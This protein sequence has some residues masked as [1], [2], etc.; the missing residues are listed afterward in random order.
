VLSTP[1]WSRAAWPEKHESRSVEFANLNRTAVTLCVMAG[2]FMQALDTTIANVALPYM[3]GSVSASQDEIAWVLTSYIVAAAIMTAPAGFLAGRFGARNVYLVSIAGFTVASM[4]CGASQTLDQIVICRVLQGIFGAALVPLAQAMLFNITPPEDRGNSMAYFS[5]VVMVAPV[6]GPVLGGWLTEYLSWRYVFY[7]NMPFGLATLI[8]GLICLP[9]PDSVSAQKFDW[10]GFAAIGIAIGA[11]QLLLDRGV[12]KDWF[13]SPEIIIEAVVAGLAFYIFLVQT[14]T[15]RQP[16]IRPALFRNRNYSAGTVMIALISLTYFASMTLQPPFL[17]GMMNYSVLTSGLTMGPRGFGTM[18]SMLVVGRLTGK[19]DVRIL[20]AFGLA[21]G[22]LSF[23]HMSH[24]TT[25][26]SQ[27]TIILT[28]VIQGVGMG[29]VFV[30]L[31]TVA[32]GALSAQQR[33]EG[34]SVFNL[35]RNLGSSAGISLM[36]GLLVHNQQVIQSGLAAGITPFNRN[37]GETILTHYWDPATRAGA[38]ALNAVMQQ[39]VGIIAYSDDYTTLMLATLFA[40][41]VLMLFKRA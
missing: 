17:Q 1:G 12:E 35:S 26:I 38:A 25:D 19:V 16:F 4:L 13:A 36:N 29:F 15:A 14:F 20:M 40:V 9:K 7:V 18:A 28:G 11:F 32:L 31:N 6:I 24:W 3:Q 5:I 33:A 30:P 21:L 34:A 2:V 37:I 22:A 39:Q 10:L 41:P 27:R 8:V 23:Y